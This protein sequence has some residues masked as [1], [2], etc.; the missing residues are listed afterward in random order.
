MKARLI[1]AAAMIG[2]LTLMSR[3]LGMIRDIVSAESFGTTWQWDA[4]IYAF[5]LPNFIRRLVGEGAL[6]SAFIPVYTEVMQKEGEE[7][8]LRFGNVI[9]TLLFW[10]LVALLLTLEIFLVFL[11]KAPLPP[12]IHLT[13]ELL[14]VFFPYLLFISLCALAMGILNCHRHFFSPALGPVILDLVWIAAVLWVSPLGGPR[15]EERVFLLALSVLISGAIQLAAQIPF[16]LR[17][18][19][20][21]RFLWGWTHPGLLRVGKLL[22]PAILGFAVVQINILVDM[23]MGFWAGA[24]A[25]SSLWYGNRL[26]QFPLGVFAIAMGTAVLPAISQ[27]TARQELEEAKR[28]LSFALRTIFFIILPST[29]GLIVLR[30]PIVQL[31]FERGEF[32]A[33]STARTAFVLL[34]YTIGLFAYSGQKIIVTG[35]YALQDTKTPMKI[36]VLALLVNLVFNFILIGPLKEG[37]LALSTSIAGIF[38]FGLLVWLF[39]RRIAGFPVREILT[40]SGRVLAASLLMGGAAWPLFGTIYELTAGAE[41]F[42][43]LGGVLGSIG[44]SV[45]IYLGLSFLFRVPEM[46]ELVEWLRR[47]KEKPEAIERVGEEPL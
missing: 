29:V 26:M 39:H 45:M 8:A 35:F 22:L 28:M 25:N 2:G 18:G 24:G 4:F 30:T 16:L 36:G 43:L 7:E 21:P 6:T 32:D 44:F 20:S 37:G 46:H 40:S 33:V 9:L 1:K 13:C 3:I 14:Q 38:N 10:G 47:S 42:R 23:T 5:M 17:I 34:G 12:V 11:L 27:H 41:T 15:A 19:F 31:L